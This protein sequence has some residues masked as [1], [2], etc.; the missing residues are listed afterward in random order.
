VCGGRASATFLRGTLFIPW[1][2][3]REQIES[4]LFEKFNRG[5]DLCSLDC[6]PR[7]E[8]WPRL[9]ILIWVSDWPLRLRAIGPPVDA[10]LPLW[11][12][13]WL[14]HR[15]SPFRRPSASTLRRAGE[16]LPVC[17]LLV[18][19][20]DFE[21]DNAQLGQTVPHK[22]GPAR[23]FTFCLGSPRHRAVTGKALISESGA[24]LG[25]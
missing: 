17:S 4:A 10:S 20:P 23:E 12:A 11:S 13:G 2:A 8:S 22:N 14:W 19:P 21:R 16:T 25:I 7:I 15:A 6:S 5:F 24:G 9:G 3:A 1:L 18:V